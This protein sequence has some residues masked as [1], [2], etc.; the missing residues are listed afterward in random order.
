MIRQP[1]LP[2]AVWQLTEIEEGRRFV[3]VTTGP[4]VSVVARHSVDELGRTS[5]ATLALEFRGL[6]GGLIGRI[7]ANLN[8]RYL[9]LEAMGLKKRSEGAA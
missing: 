3:W 5:R 8:Q 4:G 9:G 2:P 1:K 6:L 7:T